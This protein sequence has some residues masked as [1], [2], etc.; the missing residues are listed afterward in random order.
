VKG[1]R[2]EFSL[3]GLLL[4]CPVCGWLHDGLAEGEL[5]RHIVTHHADDLGRARAQ[6]E[7]IRRM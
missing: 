1:E 7:A 6:V 2:I 4:P 5:W 3:G